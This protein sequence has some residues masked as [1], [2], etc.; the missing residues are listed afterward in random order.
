MRRDSPRYGNFPKR[1]K[2]R[3]R[4]WNRASPA[5]GKLWEHVGKY[6]VDFM[7]EQ[8]EEKAIRVKC[9][10]EA[11]HCPVDETELCIII[12]NLFDNAIEAVKDLP[13]EQRQI[14]FSIQNPNGIFRIEMSNPYEDER[15]K[16]EHHYLTTK[17]ENTEMHG[18][19]LM[20][21]QKI[22]EKYDGLMEISDT[23]NVFKVIVIFFV[24]GN[25]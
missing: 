18:L 15:R 21:V 25:D 20:S 14:D 22:V 17:K 8:A 10:V 6:R 2:S 19:G 16:V 11:Y 4:P 5:F 23:D 9:A 7:E 13:D 12:G 3:E 1:R 24:R